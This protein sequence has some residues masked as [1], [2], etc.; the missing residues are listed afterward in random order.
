[1][2][3][4]LSY[5]LCYCYTHYRY[6]PRYEAQSGIGGYD[7]GMGMLPTNSTVNGI[8]SSNVSVSGGYN[9][10]SASSDY[11]YQSQGRLSRASSFSSS[12]SQVAAAAAAAGS[13][14]TADGGQRPYV[15]INSNINNPNMHQVHPRTCS[16]TR[17]RACRLSAQS[18]P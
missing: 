13:G 11:G 7:S 4:V 9:D 18:Y 1:M 16:H 17:I 14:M 5:A 12:F 10:G 8:N 3:H 15:N 6:D 2:H